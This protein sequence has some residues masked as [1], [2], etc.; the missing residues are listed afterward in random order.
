[1]C[2][3]YSFNQ[4]WHVYFNSLRMDE[5]N[6][7]IIGTAAGVFTAASMLPQLVKIVRDKKAE[8]ISIGMLLIL[9]SGLILWIFYGILKNDLPLIVTNAFSVVVNGLIVF[10]SIKYKKRHGK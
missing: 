1:M 3:S 6:P 4:E 5:I 8:D 7:A 10:F 2:K 9:L